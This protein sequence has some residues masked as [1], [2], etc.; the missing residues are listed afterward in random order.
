MFANKIIILLF[1]RDV[2][3][4]NS[5]RRFQLVQCSAATLL[6]HCFER[7][8]N[9]SNI[10]TL[11]SLRIVPCKITF[12]KLQ[13][14]RR[15]RALPKSNRSNEQ[16]NNSAHATRFFVHFFTVPAQ[17]RR[18][19]TS[20]YG[21][22]KALNSTTI[23]VWTRARSPLL[24]SNLNS[25]LLTNRVTWDI[26]EILDLK[27]WG[28]CFSATFSWTSPLSDCKVLKK[29]PMDF[30]TIRFVC[31]LNLCLAQME[32]G[33]LFRIHSLKW[34]L[35]DVLTTCK[36]IIKG[37]AI[38]FVYWSYPLR[39]KPKIN[40]SRNK[41]MAFKGG[42]VSHSYSLVIRNFIDF[43]S[44]FRHSVRFAFSFKQFS[45]TEFGICNI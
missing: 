2:T 33:K 45:S 24:S 37:L 7:W 29:S 31:H 34:N 21:N 22:G 44:L 39:H 12:M 6:R 5:Q 35:N 15:Q 13:R 18:E 11:S 42:V 20:F 16:N 28:L 23:L 10:P 19:M 36:A 3:R 38:R 32:A 4:D 9:C 1:S 25:L 26:C 27:G 14:G 8:Q 40:G 41:V 17:L 43:M 30:P